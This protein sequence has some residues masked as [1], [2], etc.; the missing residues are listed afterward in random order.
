[1]KNFFYEYSGF[2]LYILILF[3]PNIYKF[4]FT[5]FANYC[6]NLLKPIVPNSFEFSKDIF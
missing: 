4:K 3:K 5:H 6:F 1:M 2:V